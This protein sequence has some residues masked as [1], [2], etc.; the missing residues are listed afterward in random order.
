VK[1]RR[2]SPRRLLGNP[3]LSERIHDPYYSRVK[4]REATSCPQCGVRYRNGR[5]T[6]PAS[7]VSAFRS[8]LCPACR[9]INDHYPAGEL[10][11]TG[12][13]IDAHRSEIIATIRHVEESERQEHPLNRIMEIETRDD[14]LRI[15]TTDLHLPHRIAHALSDAWGGTMGTHYDR[16]GYFT[17]VIWERND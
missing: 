11:L 4:P 10:L 17:R 7:K 14:G 13:F 6:M 2:N 9:R 15:T 12:E 1:P 16:N 3:L 5:W 8:Q